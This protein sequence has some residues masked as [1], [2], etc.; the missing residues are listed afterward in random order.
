[1]FIK[2][3]KH[4]ECR[5]V[6]KYY[7][8]MD[9]K[10]PSILAHSVPNVYFHMGRGKNPSFPRFHLSFEFGQHRLVSWFSPSVTF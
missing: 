7:D 4:E 3:F 8:T 5:G 1:M 10:C 6:A 9:L 2:D